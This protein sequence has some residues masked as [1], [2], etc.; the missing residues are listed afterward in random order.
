MTSHLLLNIGLMTGGVEIA[1][2]TAYRAM[3]AAGILWEKV[4]HHD[5]P[6][7]DG[8]T[9]PTLV[10]ECYANDHQVDLVATWLEQ[11]CIAVWDMVHWE[12]RM[13][14][15]YRDRW[16]EFDPAQFV[17]LNGSRLSEARSVAA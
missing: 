3:R 9:E 17:L 1:D 15:P 16:P 10:V 11:D 2:T 13:V 12:G 8:S 14:G 6:N 5:W 4:A 7:P